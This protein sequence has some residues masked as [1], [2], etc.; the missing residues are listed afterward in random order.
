[1]ALAFKILGIVGAVV[2]GVAFVAE[3]LFALNEWLANRRLRRKNYGVEPIIKAIKTKPIAEDLDWLAEEPSSKMS[4][5]DWAVISEKVAK[6]KLDLMT[7]VAI[8]FGI[9]TTIFLDLLFPDGGVLNLVPLP[10]VAYLV[11]QPHKHTYI[12][13]QKEVFKLLTKRP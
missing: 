10:A 9:L 6:A 13:A 1:M 2:V 5:Y 4:T 7:W 8:L 12:R 11:R 3:V